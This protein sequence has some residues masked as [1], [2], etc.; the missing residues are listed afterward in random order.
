MILINSNNL[1]YQKNN[2][3]SILNLN[4]SFLNDIEILLIKSKYYLLILT[5]NKI[6]VLKEVKLLTAI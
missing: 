2:I 5:F 3:L 4:Y 6:I 1:L